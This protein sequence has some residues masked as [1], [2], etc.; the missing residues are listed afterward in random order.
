MRS[1]TRG[2]A[3]RITTFGESHGPAVGVVIDGVSPGLPLDET[4]VQVQMDRRRPGRTGLDSPRAEPDRAEIL[5]GVFEGRTTGAPVCILVR[6]V[7]ARSQDYE[8]LKD[9]LRPGHGDFGW[10]AK[11]GVRDWRG[12]G[13]LSGRETVGRVAAGAVA[14]RLLDRVGIRIAGAVV[15]IDGIRAA[16]FD[17]AFA[18]A[19]PLRCADPAVAARM[20]DRVRQVRDQGDSV[21][22]VVEVRVDGVPP[23]L[24]DPVFRRLDADLASAILS[25]GGVRGVEIGDGF[26]AARQHGS[27]FNDQPLPGGGFA[28][29]HSGGVLGGISTGQT[30]VLRLAVRPTGS[31]GR[32]QE[33]VDLA[34]RSATIEGRGR[35][36]PCL[37]PRIVPVAEAM[38]A[39]VLA[40]AL[41]RQAAIAR[42]PPT[43]DDLRLEIDRCD[44]ALLAALQHRMAVQA[45]LDRDEAA[46]RREP[47]RKR[48]AAGAALR[49]AW[50]RR[51]REIGLARDAALGVLDA[52]LRGGTPP[53]GHR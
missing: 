21:G 53:D 2:D 19:D 41:L 26:A 32:T 27:A 12:G 39:C 30:L 36:D 35:H 23:G 15:E 5:S 4:V 3:F 17:P 46:G 43:A 11:Y 28:S 25:I 34:G 16:T 6:N 51:A 10:L 20:A 45:V 22:G 47:A 40:D 29:N 1:N 13:R 52:I 9:R 38:A 49:R 48:D 7:D 24:G 14:R 37:C 44:E 50:T 31:I 18:E 42:V 8:H 33:T